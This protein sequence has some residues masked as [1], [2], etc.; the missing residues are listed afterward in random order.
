MDN[1]VKLKRQ[2]RYQELILA[3]G[4]HF[5]MTLVSCDQVHVRVHSYILSRSSYTMSRLLGDHRRFH[6]TGDITILL[7]DVDASDLRNIVKLIY[8]GEVQLE[9][10]CEEKFIDKANLLKLDN[11]LRTEAK[12]IKDASSSS[13]HAI[14]T[15]LLADQEGNM[16]E[17][18]DNVDQE[19]DEDDNEDNTDFFNEQNV[20]TVQLE[21]LKKIE[22][23]ALDDESQVMDFIKELFKEDPPRKRIKTVGQREKDPC[24]TSCPVCEKIYASIKQMKAHYRHTHV[25]DEQMCNECGLKL[26]NP[27]LLAKHKSVE[28]GEIFRCDQCDYT[29]KQNSNLKIHVATVHEKVRFYC[30]QCESSYAQKQGLEHHIRAFHEK[31]KVKCSECDF[32]STQKSHLQ[33]HYRKKHLNFRYTCEVCS[34]EFCDRY[35]FQV[36]MM[37]KHSIDIRK[38]KV[39]NKSENLTNQRKKKKV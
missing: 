2:P 3:N 15:E 24:P 19:D 30:D 22:T 16:S 9:K 37:K 20:E 13:R 39:Y 5:D 17:G 29:S 32:E 4:C 27:Y 31:I 38:H 11:F 14:E 8:S 10:D 33:K 7:P 35:N 18:E 34:Q 25:I 36:H 28:H 1:S 12:K 26:K 21:D 6:N 23:D